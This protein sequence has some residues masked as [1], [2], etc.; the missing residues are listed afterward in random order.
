MHGTVFFSTVTKF[1][2]AIAKRYGEC[3]E[4]FASLGAKDR[5][6]GTDLRLRWP[7]TPKSRNRRKIGKKG[8]S[9]FL[10]KFSYFPCFPIFCLCLFQF[11]GIWGFLLSSW[12]HATAS[13]DS[14]E[15]RRWQNATDLHG[16]VLLAELMKTRHLDN[17]LLLLAGWAP[18]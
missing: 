4:M 3:L 1:G 8:I 13:T 12:P 9:Y 6:N 16:T 2:I 18:Q 14:E 17:H 10:P 11:S 15:P 5:K 7:A